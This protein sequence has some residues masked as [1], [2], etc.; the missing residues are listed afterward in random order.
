LGWN[1]QKWL[2]EVACYI[3]DYR[4]CFRGSSWAGTVKSGWL[5]LHVTSMTIEHVSEDRVGLETSKVVGFYESV[6]A[7]EQCSRICCCERR[8]NMLPFLLEMLRFQVVVRKIM[9]MFCMP[10]VRWKK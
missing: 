5:K 2:A 4:A 1:R 7:I 8:I 3:N 9:L 6:N 10:S